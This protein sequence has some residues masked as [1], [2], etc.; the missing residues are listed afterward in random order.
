M[1]IMNFVD[2]GIVD[3]FWTYDEFDIKWRKA[4]CEIYFPKTIGY[5]YGEQ[6]CIK[7]AFLEGEFVIETEIVESNKSNFEII[8]IENNKYEI[9]LFDQKMRLSNQQVNKIKQVFPQIKK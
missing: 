2:I 1:D 5:N 6:Y 4:Y 8:N 9:V 3:V 7:L